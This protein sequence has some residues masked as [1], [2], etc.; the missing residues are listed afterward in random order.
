MTKFNA[1]IV[2]LQDIYT[3]PSEEDTWKLIWGGNI[4]FY[5]LSS[6]TSDRAICL[7]NKLDHQILDHKMVIPG[8]AL[9]VTVCTQ[10]H[11]YHLIKVYTPT[12]PKGKLLFLRTLKH[13]LNKLHY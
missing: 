4:L 13:R 3:I 9:H 6:N 2:F 11:N 7:S 5:H 1:D 10:E 8:R 12:C